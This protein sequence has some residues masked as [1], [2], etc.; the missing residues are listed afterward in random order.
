[1][2]L[3]W[4]I[5]QCEQATEVRVSARILGLRVAYEGKPLDPAR[6]VLHRSLDPIAPLGDRGSRHV[7]D[8]PAVPGE[9]LG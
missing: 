5:A 2:L 8:R 7:A 1:M 9:F 4:L 3:D 6:V